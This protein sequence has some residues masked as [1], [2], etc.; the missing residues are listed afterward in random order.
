[1]YLHDPGGKA[2]NRGRAGLQ[3]RAGYLCKGCTRLFEGAVWGYRADP[4]LRYPRH[5]GCDRQRLLWSGCHGSGSLLH[6]NAVLHLHG[7]VRQPARTGGGR[8]LKGEEAVGSGSQGGSL[9]PDPSGKYEKAGFLWS[10]DHACLSWLLCKAK[11]QDVYK[12][13]GTNRAC[14][15]ITKEQKPDAQK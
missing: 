6:G 11:D 15:A 9:Q 5:W 12:R 3:D 14:A 4:L 2:G 1:M 13:Q 7:R 8:M 10:G